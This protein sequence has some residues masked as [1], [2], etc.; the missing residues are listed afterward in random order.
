MTKKTIILV[1]LTVIVVGLILSPASSVLAAD[2]WNS[3]R[4][5]TQTAI[6]LPPAGLTPASPFYFLER[7]SEGVGTFF[8]FGDVAKAR[9]FAKLATERVAEAKAVVDQGKPE[10]AEVALTL[11]Q[12]QLGKSLDRA[13]KAQAKGKS[14]AE[15][16]EIVSQA[17]AKHLT[18]L[19]GLAEK[20]P[21]QAKAAILRAR[22]V[23]ING[24]VKALG[25]LTKEKPERAA[26]LNMQAI[27]NRLERAKMEARA[28]KVENT[29]RTLTDFGNLQASLGKMAKEHKSVLAS[30]VAN[31][32]IGQI[33]DL[34]EVENEVK[35]ISPQIA[36]KA[37]AVKGSA[38][39][40]HIEVLASLA[41][42]DPEKATEVFS[43]AAEKRLAQAQRG[44]EE[45]DPD[46]INE[47]VEEFGKYASFGQE[48]S[49][50]AQGIGGATTTV[51][52]LVAKATAHHLEVLNDVLTKAPEQAKEVIKN[53]M[54]ISEKGRQQAVES[55]KAKGA[56]KNIPETVPIP[57]EVKE[58]VLQERKNLKPGIQ[59]P[60]VQP[61]RP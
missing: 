3:S 38:I 10:A 35:N 24:Q 60:S 43:Q 57:S 2:D 44:T 15:V 6:E 22:D 45:Q 14:V 21:E 1:G 56:L 9:R 19:E 59:A 55:L 8:T 32:I 18:V 36:E 47:A 4:S 11:Y 33:E 5:N 16:T 29:E 37:K 30:L 23:S 53:S 13:E 40:R 51:E 7:F 42:I 31:S 20:V 48:I 28:G 50:I 39:T 46:K 49:G 26:N 12:D 17:T 58:K 61:S 41:S 34:D 54:T 25:S 52:Q 27:Q